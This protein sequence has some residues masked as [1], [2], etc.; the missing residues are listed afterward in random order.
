MSDNT[1]SL[2]KSEKKESKAFKRPTREQ[3]AKSLSHKGSLYFDPDLVDIENY[4]YYWF[5]VSG[6]EPMNIPKA[7]QL[8]W[9]DVGQEEATRL[10]KF[11][12]YGIFDGQGV[13]SQD[14]IY[15]IPIDTETK[16]RLMK[17]EKSIHQDIIDVYMDTRVRPISRRL[18]REKMVF[19]G[20][21]P[22]GVSVGQDDEEIFEDD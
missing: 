1:P 4:D 20:S 22:K 19:E 18:G 21:V 14:G 3:I 11:C 6:R 15:E 10:R 7:Q 2:A 12:G 13:E 5:N 9:H 16:A 17:I 8:G